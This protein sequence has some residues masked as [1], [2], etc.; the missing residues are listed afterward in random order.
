MFQV[1]CGSI[2]HILTKTGI[3][4]RLISM[5]LTA[6]LICY[7][8]TYHAKRAYSLSGRFG[9]FGCEP[10]VNWLSYT[11]LNFSRAGCDRVRTQSI[12]APPGNTSHHKPHFF[13]PTGHNDRWAF[14]FLRLTVRRISHSTSRRCTY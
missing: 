10:R 4:K 3:V 5:K 1:V 6:R 9:T 8:S 2:P 11:P 14:S 7:V 13:S 12:Y